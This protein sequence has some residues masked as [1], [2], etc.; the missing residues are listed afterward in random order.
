MIPRDKVCYV[1]TFRDAISG[2]TLMCYRVSCPTLVS[3][4]LYFHVISV[5]AID[6]SVAVC[7]VGF[8]FESKGLFYC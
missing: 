1:K 2:V 6:V 4:V 3:F 8:L 7:T 5:L